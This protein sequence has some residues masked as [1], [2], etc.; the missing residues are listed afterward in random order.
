MS[1]FGKGDERL[2]L[3]TF[4]SPLPH[5]VTPVAFVSYGLLVVNRFGR[6]G[7]LLEGGV[8]MVLAVVVI[9][10][11]HALGFHSGTCPVPFWTSHDNNVSLC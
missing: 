5:Q 11:I 7:L 8:Q 9:G 3:F 10:T 6:R 1:R 2:T 4:L